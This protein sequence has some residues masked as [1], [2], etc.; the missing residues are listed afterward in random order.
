MQNG[1]H[2][3]CPRHPAADAGRPPPGGRP[4]AATPPPAPRAPSPPSAPAVGRRGRRARAPPAD[5]RRPIA[6]SDR[7]ARPPAFADNPIVYVTPSW[8]D[9]CGFTYSEAVG[10]NPRL[11]QGTNTNLET[12][13]AI[14]C[15]LT[16]KQPCKVQLI[17]Y[18]SGD[19]AKPFWNVLSVSPVISRGSLQFF[20]V[21]RRTRRTRC[22]ADGARA[23]PAPPPR[24]CAR[25]RPRLAPRR[26][27]AAPRRLSLT[28]APLPSLSQA[29]LQ[30]YSY[31]MQSFVK[32]TPAQFCRAAQHFQ[33]GRRLDTLTPF[34]LAKPAVYEADDEF[35]LP[36]PSSASRY[37]SAVTPHPIKRLGWSSLSLEPE[38]LSARI[39]DALQRMDATTEVTERADSEGETFMVHAKLA[40]GTAMRV[41][42]FEDPA[43]GQYRISCT[44]LSGET[45][46]YHEAFRAMRTHLADAVAPNAAPPPGAAVAPEPTAVAAAAAAAVPTPG[47]FSLLA[48]S[49]GGADGIRLAPLPLSS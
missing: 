20:I 7:R 13:R 46:S 40:N 23:G 30:D 12:T 8:Q 18:R 41:A 6:V 47:P 17:N 3:L 38:H 35:T 14:S 34:R 33:R 4:P 39:E 31:Q 24:L 44:R 37:Q 11:T 1:D 32:L 5:R 22:R 10:K 2:P 27:A 42:V 43:D 26:L 49:E 29:N 45:F 19:A 15:S 16:A 25:A 28:P 9:M 48:A 36:A 21:R